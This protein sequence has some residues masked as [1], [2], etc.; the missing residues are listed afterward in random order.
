ME[1]EQVYNAYF[2][3]VYLYMMQLSG[4]ERMAEEITSEAFFKALHSVDSF[5][6]DCDMRVWLCQI[7]KNAYCSYL[8]K[9]KKIASAHEADLMNTADPDAFVE[10]Q[11]G[12]QEEARRIRKVLHKTP[13]PYLD[14]L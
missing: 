11:V 10:D 3:S 6:G 2:R 9:N 14:F 5:R 4:K 1:F 7:A 13:E 8:K 12:A